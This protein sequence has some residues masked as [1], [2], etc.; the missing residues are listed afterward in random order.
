MITVL[1]ASLVLTILYFF[2]QAR[3]H[4]MSM[5]TCF[6][7]MLCCSL[8]VS[9][10]QLISSTLLFPPVLAPQHVLWLVLFVIPLLGLTMMGN[11]V[12]ARVMTLAT[13]KNK[14]HI[15]SEVGYGVWIHLQGGITLTSFTGSQKVL[16]KWYM[17]ESPRL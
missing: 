6:Y 8:S 9:L 3:S 16:Q 5:R 15:T 2:L 11:P 1:C 17:H 13:K 4:L 14:D 12:D 10:T 7:F